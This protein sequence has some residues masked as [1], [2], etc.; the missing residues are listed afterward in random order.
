MVLD[1]H[2]LDDARLQIEDE[3]MRT[4]IDNSSSSLNTK[5]WLGHLS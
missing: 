3:A 2:G 1:E 4:E 5:G